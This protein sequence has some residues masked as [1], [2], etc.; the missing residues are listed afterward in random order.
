MA[1]KVSFYVNM[2]AQRFQV[3]VF[4]KTLQ[5]KMMDAKRCLPTE[6]TVKDV[7]Y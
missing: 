5:P 6:A 4:S 7:R 2:E 1:V 3:D